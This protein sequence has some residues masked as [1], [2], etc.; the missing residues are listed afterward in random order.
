MPG[1][2]TQGDF[3]ET[4]QRYCASFRGDQ[5]VK[6]SPLVGLAPLLTMGENVRRSSVGT[7]WEEMRS[8]KAPLD[9]SHISAGQ[10][11]Q[12]DP[13][14]SCYVSWTFCLSEIFL[15]QY[16]EALST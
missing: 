8:L 10:L 12:G 13:N 16:I 11:A 7:V 9:G 6:T 4:T 15:S 3:S 14:E 5:A 1:S 2:A